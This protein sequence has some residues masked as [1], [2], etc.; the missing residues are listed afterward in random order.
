MKKTILKNFERFKKKAKKYKLEIIFLFTALILTITSF[1][2]YEKNLSYFENKILQI[3]QK[4]LEELSKQEVKRPNKIYVDISGA[5]EKPDVYAVPEG[6]R[7]IDV[8]I[9]AGGLSAN[10][11]RDFFHRNFNLALPVFDGQ[12]IYV[13]S[14]YEIWKG[15]IKEP[16]RIFDFTGYN[17][18][19]IT[20]LKNHTSQ[21]PSKKIVNINTASR[22]ELEALPGI[23][24]IT[25]QKIIDNRPYSSIEELL[26]KKIL[27]KS[28][29][30]AIKDRLT[31]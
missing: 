16:T 5:V 4:S 22:E 15:I 7:L 19:P 28:V 21:L 2:I 8:L 12:K 10:A 13:P 24:K 25:A 20:N 17:K 29:Y 18:K 11:D 14:K 26:Q 31:L 1:V 27:R 23:G 3:E 9:M 30:E 6:S